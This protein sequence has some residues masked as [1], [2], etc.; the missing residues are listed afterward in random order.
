MDTTIERLYDG[1]YSCPSC[2]VE[3]AVD[4]ATEDDLFCEECGGDLVE[5]DAEDDDGDDDE[6]D[7]EAA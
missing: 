4:R 7:D 6:L 2:E 1:I 3:Y 5:A